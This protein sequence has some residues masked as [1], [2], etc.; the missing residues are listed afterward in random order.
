MIIDGRAIAEELYTE[1]AER[2]KQF[3][4][5]PRLGI[6]VASK[7]PVIESFVRIKGKAA[8]RL[9]VALTRTDLPD[10]ETTQ[11]AIVSLRN[12]AV[13][14]DGI[15]VQLPLPQSIDGNA[16]L[17]AIPDGND[18]D[19]IS[20]ATGEHLLEAPVALALLEILKR[21][22][23]DPKGK[24]AVV[25]GAGR[26]VGA[27]AA[28]ALKQRGANVTIVT[29]EQGSLEEL[30]DADIIVLG[31]GDPG[32]IKPE[33]IQEGAI[34]LDGGTSE[35][36]GK[37]RGDA[38]PACAEKCSVFTPV[39]GGVGP[40]AVAMIFKNLFDLMEKKNNP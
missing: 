30:K 36:H 16:L 3:A 14:S 20:T 28:Q 10:D 27:P 32:L 23:I 12:M 9:D 35:S 6:L 34:I 18:V 25:V 17:S 39:P 11:R 7:D 19:A 29:L 40:I 4:R 37:V 1:L 26:L 33:H 22:S 15:I 13:E 38:D 21:S 8:R 31:A 2:R 24:K 5:A